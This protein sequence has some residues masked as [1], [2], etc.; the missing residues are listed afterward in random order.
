MA[1]ISTAPS[2]FA[3]KRRSPIPGY[4][5]FGNVLSRDN[6]RTW[7]NVTPKDLPADSTVNRID[8]SVHQPG[9]ALVA[10]YNYRMNDWQPYIYRTDDYG[11]TWARLSD[12]RNGIPADHPTRVVR[13]D[14]A[15]KGLLYAGTEF[16]LFVS[17]DDGASWQSLQLNLPHTPVTDLLV[18]DDDLIVATQGRYL[19]AYPKL[20]EDPF[21]TSKPQ[22][23][24]LREVG[25]E[26][27]PLGW[28]GKMSPAFGEIVA[29]SMLSKAVHTVL[30][31]NVDPAEAVVKLHEEIVATYRR[32]REP[33]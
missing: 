2:G 28:E 18:K 21:W 29:Q 17:S 30:I 9:R 25:R 7:T 8:L 20:L 10:I 23:A 4:G 1:K 14:P 31:N 16:G 12:G 24:A 33:G 6:G 13:E 3:P 32:L 11:R 27:V 5:N 15:R 19:P 22:F 26:G